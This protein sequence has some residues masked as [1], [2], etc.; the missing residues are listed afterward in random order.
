MPKL[1]KFFVNVLLTG[2]DKSWNRK[3]YG[4]KSF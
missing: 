1:L 4:V 3:V 2:A